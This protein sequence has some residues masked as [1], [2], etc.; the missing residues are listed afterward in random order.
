MS[1]YTKLFASILESTVWQADDATR[2]VWITMLAMKDRDGIVEASIPGL[3]ARA[4]QSIPA[5]ERALALLMAPDLYSRTK[6]HDGRRIVEI[7]GGWRLL[8]HDKYNDKSSA[9]EY[10][11]KHAERQARY[12]ARVAAAKAA[13]AKRDATGDAGDVVVT[14]GDTAC[15]PSAPAPAPAPISERD[16]VAS[17]DQPA[18]LVMPERPPTFD[19]VA[20][21]KRH[22]RHEG[23]GKG[24]AKLKAQI[25]TAADYEALCRA[26]A[27]Y[28]ASK[29]VRDGFV[30]HFDTWV[31]CWRDYL[32]PEH[33][34]AERPY[35]GR[36]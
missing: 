24:L 7:D 16:L 6:D 19:L 10:R 25:R 9:E 21:Y 17:G 27:A 26:Q 2:L 33:K 8:N 11:Q 5:T 15:L 34:T 3:A 28:L 29:A 1:S 23:K 13:R 4:R 22:P 36:G 18:L 12:R 32:E 30:K 20:I 14:V 31:N 35:N